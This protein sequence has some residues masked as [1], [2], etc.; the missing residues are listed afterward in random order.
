M[1]AALPVAAIALAAGGKLYEGVEARNTAYRAAGDDFENARLSIL[2][3]EQDV[4]GIFDEERIAAG[5]SL[6]AQGGNGLATGGSIT[7]LIEQS[8]YAAERHAA[9]VRQ[10]AYGEAENYNRRGDESIRAGKSALI[11]GIF[12]AVSSAIGGAGDM[13]AQRT[14]S[15]QRASERSVRLGRSG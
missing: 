1:A 6:A 7:T 13:R 2:A 14:L 4:T 9:A 10:R 12:N 3:G 8:A 11:A 5:A 15:N